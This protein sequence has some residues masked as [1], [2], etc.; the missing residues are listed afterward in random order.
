M[1]SAIPLTGWYADPDDGFRM[2]YWDGSGWAEQHPVRRRGQD[3]P[4]W[5]AML[6]SVADLS[7]YADA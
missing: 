4:A 6:A 1:I 7:L 3:E 2:R 5:L